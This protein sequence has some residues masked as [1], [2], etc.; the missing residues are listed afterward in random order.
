MSYALRHPEVTTQLCLFAYS[1]SGKAIACGVIE[2]APAR[3]H[4]DWNDRP[5]DNPYWN[6][7]DPW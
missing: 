7:Y 3:G 6:S 2:M 4:S 1:N 5:S